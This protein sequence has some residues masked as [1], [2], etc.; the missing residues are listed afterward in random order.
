LGGGWCARAGALARMF[1]TVADAVRRMRRE[2]PDVVLA[3]GSYA[4]IGPGLAARWLGV[5]LVLHEGNAVPGRAVRV[6]APFAARIGVGFEHTCVR[7]ARSH[8]VYCGFPVRDGFAGLQ[9]SPS[10]PPL[11]LV[12][13]GSQGAA[14]LNRVVP[15]AVRMVTNGGVAMRVVHLTGRR[16]YAEVL[17][18]YRGLEHMVTVEAF[19][20][21][22]PE[23]YAAA[24]LAITRAG[25]ATCTELALAQVPAI[26][27]PFAAAAGNHQWHNAQ[28]MARS[29]GF[30][31]LAETA[32][33][34]SVVATQLQELF[35]NPAHL[36]QMQAALPGGVI[37]D[38]AGKLADLVEGVFVSG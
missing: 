4:S 17:E 2:P 38:G 1:G 26:L 15:E 23:L 12:T 36:Q 8:T 3:M 11:L 16:A 21:R 7:R 28:A 34:A 35:A 22:M 32:C 13:G 20:D 6:L 25:A 9:K 27:V 10:E 29:G 19:S 37:P 31:V 5:P 24:R 30:R 18:R 33:S 14:I